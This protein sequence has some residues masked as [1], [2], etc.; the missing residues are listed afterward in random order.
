MSVVYLNLNQLNNPQT[1]RPTCINQVDWCWSLRDL[2]Q[3]A[4]PGWGIF[5]S[6]SFCS[7]SD[8][9]IDELAE[10]DSKHLKMTKWLLSCVFLSK[11]SIMNPSFFPKRVESKKNMN[12]AEPLCRMDHWKLM[13]FCSPTFSMV[14]YLGETPQ[15]QCWKQLGLEGIVHKQSLSAS[16]NHTLRRVVMVHWMANQG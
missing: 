5:F 3:G 14:M 2:W 16:F 10:Q 15:N 1:S 4:I 8:N 6:D 12:L 9:T 7:K 13:V 11:S